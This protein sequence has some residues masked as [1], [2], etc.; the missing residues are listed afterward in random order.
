MRPEKGT[1]RRA[2][3]AAVLALA[4]L[5]AALLLVRLLKP[6]GAAAPGTVYSELDGVNLTYFDFDKDNNKRMEVRCRESRKHDSQRMRMKQVEATIFRSGRIEKDI[7]VTADSGLVSNNLLHFEISGRARIV[8]SDFSLSGPRFALENREFLSSRDTVAYELQNLRG[9]AAAGMEY[10]L[11]Q[12]IV[13]L[14]ETRGTMTRGG[15]PYAYYAQALW[16]LEKNDLIIFQNKGEL[17]GGGATVRG[18]WFS[19][20]FAPDFA[21]LRSAFVSGNCFFSQTAA[22]ADGSA[23]TREVT[24][25]AIELRYDGDGRLE[26]ILVTGSGR[27]ALRDRNG[28]AMIESDHTDIF[29][30]PLSQSLDRVHVK[31]RGTL[32]RRGQ[33]GMVLSGDSLLAVYSAAGALREV[34]VDDRCEF[35]S[36]ELR[37][38]A[39][40][41]VYDAGLRQVELTGHDATVFSKKNE[42]RSS[43]FLIDTRKRQLRSQAG[44]KATL[45]PERKSVLLTGKPLFITAASLDMSDRGNSVRFRDKVKLFQDDLELRAGELAIDGRTNRIAAGGRA[46]LKFLNQGEVMALRGQSISF[47]SPQ[48]RIVI[49]GGAGLQQGGNALNGRHIELAFGS[50]DQLE[51]ILARDNVTFRNRDLSGKSGSLIWDFAGE[52]I[53]FKDSAQISRQNAGTTRGRELFLN[54]NSSEIVVSS[55]DERSETVIRPER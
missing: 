48:G 36:D 9:S 49:S 47:D 6:P 17:S 28:L 38:T 37:G 44:V 26:H 31:N 40:F 7:R 41:I 5:L 27:I 51:T 30:Q 32:T 16:V 46:D 2:W 45:E 33:D 35:R 13:K 3:L 22:G 20:Q 12:N 19:L 1:R 43:R 21:R 23:T 15:E 29:I 18:D 10:F 4:A 55:R 11:D 50:T 42:F 54:L 25:N 52:T 53:L 39:A 24:A 34:R 14:F 8:S